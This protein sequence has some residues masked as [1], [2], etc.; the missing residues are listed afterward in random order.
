VAEAEAG[1]SG[2][3]VTVIAEDSGPYLA[4]QWVAAL[5]GAVGGAVIGLAWRGPEWG[6]TPV[7]RFL[8]AVLAGVAVALLLFGVERVRR[9][10]IGAA[11]LRRRVHEAAEATFL[12]EGVFATRRRTGILIY[13]SLFE[14][15]AVVLA[16]EGVHS[17]VDERAWPDMVAS[18]SA[19]MEQERHA[20]GV[21]EAVGACAEI[22]DV[23]ALVAGPDDENELDD[24]PRIPS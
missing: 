2:E 22:L 15:M 17:A 3:I 10:W 16:D 14:R 12:A 7:T 24:H 1:T 19:A 8:A 23:H 13:L 9:G 20:E 6:G 11:D 18:L 5:T 4:V 21:L